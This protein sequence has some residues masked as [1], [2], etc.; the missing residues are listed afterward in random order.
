M[1]DKELDFHQASFAKM[2][3]NTSQSGEQLS[4]LVNRLVSAVDPLKDKF[5]GSGRNSLDELHRRAESVS[6]LVGGDLNSLN[7]GQNEMMNAVMQGDEEMADSTRSQMS[8]ANFDA[9]KLRA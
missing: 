1:S 6:I 8:A 9:G 4:S 2:T 3:S 5:E 7:E